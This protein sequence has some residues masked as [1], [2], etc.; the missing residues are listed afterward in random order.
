MSTEVLPM[1][2]RCNI[3][4]EY[5]YQEPIR[6]ASNEGHPKYDL[7]AMKD[8][9][10]AHGQPFSLFG[11][12]PLLVPKKDL[13]E[14]FRFG[15]ETFGEVAA[16]RGS[17]V[18]SIQTNG[19]L[20]D[21]EHLAMFQKYRVAVGMSIDGP[22]MLNDARWAGDIDATRAAT[23]RSEWALREL[24]SRK[25][26]VSIIITLNRFNGAADRHPILATW[27]TEM[28][29]LGLRSVNVHLLQMNSEQIKQ[30]LGL[31]PEENADA[32]IALGRLMKSTPLQIMPLTDMRRLQLGQDGTT[33]TWNACD[34]YNTSA[35]FGVDGHGNIGNCGRT[36]KQ[37]PHWIKSDTSGYERYLGLYYTP[38]EYGGC[39]GCRF[40][41]AC[42][43]HCPGEGAENQDWRSKTVHCRTLQILFERLEGIME[44]Q[45]L[46]PIS[47][48]DVIRRQAEEA[49]LQAWKEGRTIP[50]TV[51]VKGPRVAAQPVQH[52]DS[53]HLDTPHID[54]EDKINPH[55][56][57]DDHNDG[58]G[59]WAR[60]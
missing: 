4:C 20:V 1:G 45:N 11:G 52:V 42:K 56:T 32:L 18:N 31:T 38:Q 28:A 44:Q 7:R 33:C 46:L 50:L 16:G 12:E 47:K 14:L 25:M 59:A 22:G 19:T 49:Y 29:A 36:C 48:N 57:H 55:V 37:G 15:L 2:E 24:L 21:E 23:A 51:A 26:N 3:R 41:F 39:S 5:C 53:P 13:E 17:W 9:L 40:F 8:A 27:L 54:H 10:R 35:V 58:G 60:L 34:T 43:G 30:D 6:R